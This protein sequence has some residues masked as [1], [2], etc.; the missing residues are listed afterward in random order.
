MDDHFL[1]SKGSDTWFCSGRILVLVWT[2]LRPLL[3]WWSD[4]YTVLQL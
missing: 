4:E 2:F 1:I 3:A